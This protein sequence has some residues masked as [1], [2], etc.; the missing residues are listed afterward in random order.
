MLDSGW[1]AFLAAHSTAWPID[2]PPSIG[3]TYFSTHFSPV[4][5]L[6]S[7]LYRILAQAGFPLYSAVWFSL[8]QGVW[9]GLLSTSVFILLSDRDERKNTASLI[10][11]LLISIASAFNGI[12]L[13][14][15]GFP[16]FE[17]AIPSLLMGFFAFYYSGRKKIAFSFLLLGLSMR[18]DAGLHY[19]GVFIVFA[20]YSIFLQKTNLSRKN[21]F[22]FAW[23]AVLCLIYS[24]S[25]VLIQNA[26]S[27]EGHN[28]LVGVYLGHPAFSHLDFTFI[29]D[30]L[31]FVLMNRMYIF[32]PI[33]IT[34]VL[35]VVR[36]DTLILIG[37]ISVTPWIVFSLTGISFQAGTLT[38]YYAF[39]VIIGLLWPI[40]YCRLSSVNNFMSGLKSTYIQLAVPAV[41]IFSSIAF[42]AGSDGNHDQKPWTRFLPYWYGHINNNQNALEQFFQENSTKSFI[43]DDAVASLRTEKIKSAEWRYQL[44]FSN[45]DLGKIDAIVFQPGSWLTSRVKE[46]IR[47]AGFFNICRVDGMSY[48]V[49]SKYG[50]LARCFP[51]DMAAPSASNFLQQP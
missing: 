51:E 5:Y 9:F 33:L 32:T 10:P 30:R 42:Y 17:I 38:N 31:Q 41:I 34:I 45:S 43:V 44:G 1:F 40:V 24:I 11:V 50:D 37:A 22:H 29:K 27:L 6:L 49:A 2:N 4:F 13:A 20:L 28:T 15:I 47:V 21:G 7:A 36:R 23:L 26:F 39:P 25:A 14:T 16:H 12:S 46:I 19:F 35:A 18:E 48:V 3:G 8:T